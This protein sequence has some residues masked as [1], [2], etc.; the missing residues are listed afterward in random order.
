MCSCC[1]KSKV[2]STKN[3]A[4]LQKKLLCVDKKVV[5]DARKSTS[6]RP[7]KV[8]VAQKKVSCKKKQQVSTAQ[9]NVS[10]PK[11]LLSS[12]RTARHTQKQPPRCV[13]K[14]N[15]SEN[16]QQIYRRTPM[17]KCVFNQGIPLGGCFLILLLMW[18]S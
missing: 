8:D 18:E 9:K 14:K 13:L 2:V 15:C 3:K 7:K 17:L 4:R 16:M 11:K 12:S 1:T 5:Y 6:C 10:C